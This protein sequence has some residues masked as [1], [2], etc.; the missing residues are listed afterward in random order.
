MLLVYF[1]FNYLMGLKASFFMDHK[2]VVAAFTVRY[3]PNN[4]HVSLPHSHQLLASAF[5]LEQL[6]PKGIE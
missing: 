3:E 6:Q 5:N 4:V 1:P 2:R